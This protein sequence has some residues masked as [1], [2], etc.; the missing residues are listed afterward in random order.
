[1]PSPITVRPF[2]LIRILPPPIV[3]AP[4]CGAARVTPKRRLPTLPKPS[5]SIPRMPMHSS[6]AAAPLPTTSTIATAPSR[7]LPALRLNPRLAAALRYR[8]DEYR[9]KGDYDR[10]LADHD[11]ALRIAPNYA[12]VYFD[13]AFTWKSK[14]DIDRAI[15]DFGEAIRIDPKYTDAY[16]QRARIWNDNKHDYD[17]A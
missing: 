17:R 16:F 13:R 6:S 2:G 3:S 4:S 15:A 1:M 11:E 7:T 5:G 12:G 9:R 8:G 14:G 10:A